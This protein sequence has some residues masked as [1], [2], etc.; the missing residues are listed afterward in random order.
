MPAIR[1]MSLC[2]FACLF[3]FASC[4]RD[5]DKLIEDV[6]SATDS[7]N[8][9]AAH[10]RQIAGT[11]VQFEVV[12]FQTSKGGL[13]RVGPIVVK[14]EGRVNR[15]RGYLARVNH[16]ERADSD[17]YATEDEAFVTMIY[18]G[19]N[20]R[21][22]RIIGGSIYFCDDRRTSGTVPF[23]LLRFIEELSSQFITDNPDGVIRR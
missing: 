3:V 10:L 22:A 8:V 11:L 15:M 23:Q 2:L 4:K 9:D 19:V 5:R 16:I 7:E 20:Q 14:D 1:V 12:V 18:S 6:S 17:Q 21:T 13:E